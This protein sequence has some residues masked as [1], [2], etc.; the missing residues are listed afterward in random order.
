MSV[1][2]RPT[3]GC[4]LCCADTLSIQPAVIYEDILLA[5]T[6]GQ[7]EINRPTRWKQHVD[8]QAELPPRSSNQSSCQFIMVTVAMMAGRSEL[9]T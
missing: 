1:G 6:P 3:D 9:P 2:K 4:V 7:T 5:R 8:T